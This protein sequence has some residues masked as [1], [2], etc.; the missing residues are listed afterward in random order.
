MF[1]SLIFFVIRISIFRFLPEH[2]FSFRHYSAFYMVKWT[3]SQGQFS[4]KLRCASFCLLTELFMLPFGQLPL[5][6][7]VKEDVLQYQD[8]DIDQVKLISH[9]L[10]NPANRQGMRNLKIS[11]VGRND[12]KAQFVT[13][14]VQ[15]ISKAFPLPSILICMLLLSN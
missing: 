13:M 3:P 8:L 12:K 9:L 5:P 15:G 10:P 6:T 11:P 2:D 1:W 4:P 14:I 7:I